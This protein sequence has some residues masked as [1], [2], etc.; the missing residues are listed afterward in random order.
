MAYDAPHLLDI[1]PDVNAL[2]AH[3]ATDC[4]LFFEVVNLRAYWFDNPTIFGFKKPRLS[5]ILL[6]AFRVVTRLR[7]T[8][9]ALS[10]AGWL[11]SADELFSTLM[12]FLH[13]F[14]NDHHNAGIQLVY[15]LK[16]ELLPPLRDRFLRV[17]LHVD[18]PPR[19]PWPKFVSV[20]PRYHDFTAYSDD[21]RSGLHDARIGLAAVLRWSLDELND[22]LASFA[23]PSDSAESREYS[24]AL[25]RI[26]YDRALE[27]ELAGTPAA[28]FM[29][30]YNDYYCRLGTIPPHLIDPAKL[31]GMCWFVYRTDGVYEPNASQMLKA[32]EGKS[33]YRERHRLRVLEIVSEIKHFQVDHPDA[34]HGV[35][36]IRSDLRAESQQYHR[37]RLRVTYPCHN[38]DGVRVWDIFRL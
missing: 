4:A 33:F 3:Q 15:Y 10:V 32:V 16:N 38:D 34:F 28:L 5:T 37:D 8:S 17:M 26:M 30:R 7:R 2:I 9:K 20:T 1:F 13:F 22:K 19:L 24:I 27:L 23:E 6:P 18:D 11:P 14:T 31:Y 36:N 35:I 25:M 29:H 21:Q 12:L